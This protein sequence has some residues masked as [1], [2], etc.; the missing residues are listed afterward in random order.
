MALWEEHFAAYP[1]GFL[2]AEVAA[3]Y[4]AGRCSTKARPVSPAEFAPWVKHRRGKHPAKARR[5]SPARLAA[6]FRAAKA[7]A[8]KADG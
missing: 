3:V 6:A 7:R 5:R 1:P 2:P 8:R 4:F